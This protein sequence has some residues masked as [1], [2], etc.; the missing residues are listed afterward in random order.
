MIESK[1]TELSHFFNSDFPAKTI[2]EKTFLDIIN[3]QTR[4]NTISAI[5]AYFLDWRMSQPISDLFIEVL[6]NI[7]EEKAKKR[8]DLVEY[9]VY[10]EY[11]TMDR[12]GR[13]DIVLF[14]KIS[15]SVIIIENKIYHYLNNDLQNYWDTFPHY[16][17][18]NKVGIILA[19]NNLPTPN[20]NYISISHLEL[21]NRIEEKGIP[22]NIS[23]REKIH[24]EDF[25]SNIKEITKQQTMDEKV[26][27]Y[28]E[29]SQKIEL[30]LGFRTDTAR[31]IIESIHKTA[32]SFNWEV[33]GNTMD[34]KQIW[35]EKNDVRIFYTLFP[36]LL[37]TKKELK[38][39]IEIDSRAME[40]YD[41]IHYFLNEK[42]LFN[43]DFCQSHHKTNHCAHLGF[44]S[45][46]LNE[47]DYEDLASL[48]IDKVSKLEPLRL[49]ILEKMISLGYQHKSA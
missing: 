22:T 35:D 31:Y 12:K 34:Y 8:Y 39:V 42:Q 2:R 17:H 19:L 28:L 23:L 36:D 6:Q 25:I 24:L 40:F 18:C 29:H 45:Y 13:I 26:K 21:I 5:Y 4:E 37:L 32:K 14:S 27:F 41:E 15:K 47:E 43:D 20:E 16:D 7:I 49:S 1:L 44:V 33:Y 48:I 46:K 3:Y 10:T 11:P 30:A 9:E 38:I